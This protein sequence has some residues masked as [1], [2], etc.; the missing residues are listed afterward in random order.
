MSVFVEDPD[1]VAAGVSTG[2]EK[3]ACRY[4]FPRNSTCMCLFHPGSDPGLEGCH[5][6][7]FVEHSADE[8][9]PL[10]THQ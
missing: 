7:D 4:G 1:M 6:R 5:G 2:E 3:R 9:I 10:A 8:V